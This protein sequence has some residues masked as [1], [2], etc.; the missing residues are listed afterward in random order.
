MILDSLRYWVTE[1]HVDGFRFDLLSALTRTGKDVDM[2]S[3]LLVAIGQDPVLRHVKLIA[4]PWDASMDGYR[5][6]EFPPP[7][8]EWNDQFRDEIRDFWLR[9]TPGDPR[10]RHPAGRLLRPVRRRRPLAVRLGQLRHRPRRLHRARPG[11]LRPQAQRGERRGQPG[12][13]RQQPVLEPRRR[14]RDHRRGDP[15]GCAAAAGRQPDGDALPVQRRPD[16]HRRRRARPH[17]GRQQQPL[18]PGQRDLLDRLAPPTTPGSTSTRSPRRRCGCAASTPR[19]A[20]GTGSRAGRPS[21]AA[22]R[23]W[24]GC[25]PTA[26]R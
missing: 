18:L 24:P 5:V 12:R 17:P 25:T 8:V 15:R 23:T 4:E 2:R 13:H 19:C 7:W 9:G 14:G 22:P 6:G 11:Q 3:H 21:A 10:R 20:S 16:D 26:A 1:M